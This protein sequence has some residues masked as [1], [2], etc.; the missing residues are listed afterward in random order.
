MKT[1]EV[2]NKYNTDVINGLVKKY[3]ISKRYIYW[4]LKG[5]K[6][7][8]NAKE[9]IEDYIDTEIKVRMVIDNMI[10]SKN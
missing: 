4:V 3:G 9:I 5:E 8:H 7:P 10:N 6:E 1:K 2:K